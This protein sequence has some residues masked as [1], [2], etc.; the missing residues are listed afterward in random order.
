MIKHVV[1]FK[2]KEIAP[3]EKMHEALSLKLMLDTLPDKI[4][5]IKFFETGMNFTVSERAFDIVLVSEFNSI[6]DLNKYQKHPEHLKVV[7]L[8]REIC[9]T[10]HV[11]DYEV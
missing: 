2:L 5:G 1:M 8:I 3:D 11:V 9:E 4:K 10:T 7:G 6:G